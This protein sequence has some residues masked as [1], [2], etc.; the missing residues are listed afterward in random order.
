LIIGGC[1]IKESRWVKLPYFGFKRKILIEQVPHFIV[2]ST[3]NA[4]TGVVTVGI[5]GQLIV[6]IDVIL[7]RLHVVYVALTEGH[8]GLETVSEPL[9]VLFQGLFEFGRTL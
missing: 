1:I 3:S 9:F 4:D 8:G 2:V 6:V 7:P 5:Q